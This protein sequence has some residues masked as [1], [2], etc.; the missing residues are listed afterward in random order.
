MKERLRAAQ[1]VQI[2]SGTGRDE[3]NDGDETSNGIICYAEGQLEDGHFKNSGHLFGIPFVKRSASTMSD[4]KLKNVRIC[5][6]GFHNG[7]INRDFGA[8]LLTLK[9]VQILRNPPRENYSELV[10]AE[11]EGRLHEMLVMEF[12]TE[13]LPELYPDATF[14][15]HGISLWS[16]GN[17]GATQ[18]LSSSLLARLTVGMDAYNS[19]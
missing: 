16:H 11:N 7:Y 3:G 17:Q 2:V 15:F 1:K 4:K 12:I 19:I 14:T 8:L 9:M 13:R 18:N 10:N 5:L 6:G